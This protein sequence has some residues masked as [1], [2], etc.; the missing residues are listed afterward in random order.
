MPQALT[1]EQRMLLE[2]NKELLSH[3]YDRG[4]AYTNLILGAGYAGF[5]TTWS[6]T[7]DRLSERQ[8]LW[9]ALLV[10]LSLISFVVFEVYK[11]FYLSQS[12]LGLTRAVQDP[13]NINR[14]IE[15]WQRDARSA[16]IRFGRIWATTFWFT[17][18]TGL[19]GGAI[20]IYS[21]VRALFQSYFGV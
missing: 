17:L 3:A 20:L 7:K 8:T 18:L 10:S 15:E 11:T 6:F 9:S 1:H 14:L 13:A 2:A 19:L 4:M 5:F 12:L 16:Q 21:F